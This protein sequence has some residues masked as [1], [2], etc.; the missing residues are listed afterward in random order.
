MATNLAKVLILEGEG[1][2]DLNDDYLQ[3]TEQEY[4]SCQDLKDKHLSEPDITLLTAGSRF[5]Q[6]GQ[7]KVMSLQ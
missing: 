5:V 4:S 6:E 3:N 7:Q 1:N 2:A